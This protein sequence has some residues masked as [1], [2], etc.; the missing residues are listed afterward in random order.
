MCLSARASYE[1]VS[2]VGPLFF[3]TPLAARLKLEPG[4][5]EKQL[6]LLKPP[7]PNQA[8]AALRAPSAQQDLLFSSVLFLL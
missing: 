6:G 3:I 5:G 1:M 2:L 7:H 8:A 4:V